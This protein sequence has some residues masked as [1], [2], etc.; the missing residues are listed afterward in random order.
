MNPKENPC[1]G[2][3]ARYVGCH[4]T[5]KEYKEWKYA[6]I[7]KKKRNRKETDK[8]K[9]FTAKEQSKFFNSLAYEKRAKGIRRRRT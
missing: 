5:C 2:C 8:E 3:V 7:E 9:Y 1:Y 4:G 6:E